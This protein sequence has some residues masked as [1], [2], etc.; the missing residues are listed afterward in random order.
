MVFSS[1][2]SAAPLSNRNSSWELACNVDLLDYMCLKYV[3]L[4]V[5]TQAWGQQEPTKRSG[6]SVLIS[7]CVRTAMA[8][9]LHGVCV[10]AC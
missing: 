7:V 2:A 8:G 4:Q 1:F 9:W 10:G 6:E 5:D 3:D